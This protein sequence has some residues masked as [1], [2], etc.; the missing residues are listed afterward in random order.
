LTQIK[1]QYRKLALTYHPD[2]VHS[3]PEKEKAFL[4]I[5]EAYEILLEHHSKEIR[6]EEFRAE[7]MEQEQRSREEVYEEL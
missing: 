5:K 7:R 1:E 4:V 6:E 3:T 2:S